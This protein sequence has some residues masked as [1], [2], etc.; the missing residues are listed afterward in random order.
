MLHRKPTY[1]GKVAS[2]ASSWAAPLV[3]SSVESLRGGSQPLPES[4]RAFFEPRFGFDFRRVRIHTDAK[5]AES[6]RAINARAFTF[7]RDIAFGDGQY[8]PDTDD[9]RRL[10]AHELAHVV[11]QRSSGTLV[12]QRQQPAIQPTCNAV[13]YDPLQQCCCDDRILPGPCAPPP[14]GG[15]AN[16]TS[17]DIEY[18]GCSVPD[19]LVAEGQDKDN[20]GGANDTWFS[21]RSIHGTQIRSYIPTLPCDI[22]D[23][24]YQTCGSDRLQCDNQLFR[25]AR[26]VCDNSLAGRSSFTTRTYLRCID[27]VEQA[28]KL[29]SMGSRGPFNTRQEEYCNCCPPPPPPSIDPV[30]IKF[31]TNVAKLDKAAT[32]KLDKFVTDNAATFASGNYDLTLIGQASRLGDPTDNKNLSQDRINAV[33]DYLQASPT[34]GGA[35]IGALEQPLGAQ[36]AEVEGKGPSDDSAEYRIVT[37]ILVAK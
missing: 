18:D 26:A 22:H 19:W 4:V 11:Q 32:D 15:C 28:E 13:P 1:Q 21:D 3:E 7:S 31:R 30:E 6:A 24:C 37:V 5:A 8:A 36:L 14:G 2:S 20:P 33:R 27:A 10:L 34:I 9:G 25:D 12:V 23:R 17:R 29:L 16:L 35:P